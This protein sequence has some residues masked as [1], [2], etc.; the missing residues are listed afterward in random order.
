MLIS[1]D[2]KF[3]SHS[4]VNAT[5]PSIL[6]TK[7]GWF[8]EQVQRTTYKTNTKEYKIM[9]LILILILPYLCCLLADVTWTSASYQDEVFVSLASDSSKGICANELGKAFEDE[10]NS[11]RLQS[12]V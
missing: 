10:F 4:T 6:G 1:L 11:M 12:I 3:R 9:C 7:S 2:P 5:S 8:V